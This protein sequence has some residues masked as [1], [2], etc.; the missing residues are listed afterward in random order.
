M[1][2]REKE[3]IVYCILFILFYFYQQFITQGTRA[4]HSS[5]FVTMYIQIG[6]TW[7][8]KQKKR[9]KKK[10]RRRIKENKREVKYN[11]KW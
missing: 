9:E 10:R 7:K 2:V 1:V 6:T 11:I 8:E 3:A 5:Y 4:D